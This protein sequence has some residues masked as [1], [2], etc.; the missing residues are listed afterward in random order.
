M[1][2]HYAGKDLLPTEFFVTLEKIVK[3]LLGAN[4]GANSQVVNMKDDII[5]NAKRHI[6]CNSVKYHVKQVGCHPSNRDGEGLSDLRA[7]T[8]L[9]VIETG[10][11]SLATIRPN[12]VSMQENPTTRRIEKNMIQQCAKSLKY[13]RQ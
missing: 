11:F 5:D 10:G 7:Q 9:Q 3:K 8:R 2:I 4:E 1:Q 13:V 12:C 6:F